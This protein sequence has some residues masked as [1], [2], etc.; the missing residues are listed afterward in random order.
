MRIKA[1]RRVINQEVAGKFS[2][3]FDPCQLRGCSDV[4][5][6][7]ESFNS[8]CLA[9]LDEVAPMKSNIVSIKKPCP[10]IN[11]SIQSCRSKRRKIEHLWKTTK[12]EVHRLYLRELVLELTTSLS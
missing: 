5:V 6:Y 4:N 11:T 7:A 10:W 9:I 3:L 2:I 8:Q 1:Q 12:L